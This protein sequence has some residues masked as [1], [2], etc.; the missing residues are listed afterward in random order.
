MS[1][2]FSTSYVKM[3]FFWSRDVNKQPHLLP[4]SGQQGIQGVLNS[5]K[6]SLCLCGMPLAAPVKDVWDPP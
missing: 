5:L 3:A 2:G 1:T 6:L 4:E